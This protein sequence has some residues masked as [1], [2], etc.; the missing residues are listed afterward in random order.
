VVDIV[1]VRHAATTWSGRRYCGVSDPPLS[2]HGRAAAARLGRELAPGLAPATRIVSSPSERAVATA[3]AIADAGVDLGVDPGVVIDERWREADVGIAEGRTFEEL[4]AVAPELADA[5]AR[6]ELAIDWPG[7]ETHASLAARVA[8]AWRDLVAAGRPAVVV[9]HAGPLL[10]AV[11]I[12]TGRGIRADDLVGPGGAVHLSVTSQGCRRRPCYPPAGD[13]TPSGSAGT[14]S[15]VPS[16]LLPAADPRRAVDGG[17][18]GRRLHRRRDRQPVDRVARILERRALGYRVTIDLRGPVD[19]PA[20]D[21]DP[22]RIT[23]PDAHADLDRG[24]VDVRRDG[25]N[26]RRDRRQP[27]LLRWRR[28]RAGL[29]GVLPGP[30]GSLER[31][32][33][34][35]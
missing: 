34:Q 10:H 15:I 31:R 9:T 29:A 6:G 12:A 23:E 21:V 35:L 8:E 22:D 4:Q 24:S 16:V 33:G 2:G 11:A 14:A 18:G 20:S 28:G 5:L 25:R 19:R 13:A 3:D 26:L 1:L 7:G 30:A 32:H 17:R 27:R